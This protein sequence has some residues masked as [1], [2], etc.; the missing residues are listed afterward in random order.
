AAGAK[1]VDPALQEI[2]VTFDRDMDPKSFAFISR[3]SGYP[4]RRGGGPYWPDARTCVLP[5]T[6]EPGRDYWVG[7]NSD[8]F[9]GFKSTDGTAAAPYPIAFHTAGEVVAATQPATK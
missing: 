2:R 9:E 5:V 1:D 4:G 6:L 7:I 3:G 8:K